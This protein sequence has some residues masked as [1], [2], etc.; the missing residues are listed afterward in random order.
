[1]VLQ[2]ANKN[3][4]PPADLRCETLEIASP[5]VGGGDPNAPEKN[6]ND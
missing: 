6:Q 3:A 5:N 4:A 2:T 1:M